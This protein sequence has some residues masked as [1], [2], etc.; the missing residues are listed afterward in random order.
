MPLATELLESYRKSDRAGS[1]RLSLQL[2][3]LSGL[4]LGVY[5]KGH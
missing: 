5:E 1:V 2:A 3:V 4:I